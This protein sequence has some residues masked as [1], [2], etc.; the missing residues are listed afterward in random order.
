VGQLVEGGGDGRQ[1]GKRNGHAT[2]M[3][4]GGADGDLSPGGVGARGGGRPSR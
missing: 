4:H 1:F 3:S 2:M